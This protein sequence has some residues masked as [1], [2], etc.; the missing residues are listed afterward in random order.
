MKKSIFFILVSIVL[1]SCSKEDNIT[2][3]L[4]KVPELETS[5]KL[6][7]RPA[8]TNNIK[9]ITGK[10]SA[11]EPLKLVKKVYFYSDVIGL[12]QEEAIKDSI[13]IFK[14]TLKLWRGSRTDYEYDEQNQLKSTKKYIAGNNGNQVSTEINF[15]DTFSYSN[16]KVSTTAENRYLYDVKGNIIELKGNDG[17]SIQYSYDDFDRI[18]KAQRFMPYDNSNFPDVSA[19]RYIVDFLYLDN[20]SNKVNIVAEY[21]MQTYDKSGY[22]IKGQEHYTLNSDIYNIDTSKAGVYA[23]EA[24]YKISSFPILHYMNARNDYF[25]YLWT[26]TNHIT[27][28]LWYANRPI[29]EY[30]IY[31]KEGYLIKKITTTKY[32]NGIA[33]SITLFEY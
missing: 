26:P 12:T 6:K 30:Y 2:D 28:W 1:F 15:M 22:L 25:S 9:L 33:S 29:L 7:F 17:T 32:I 3:E 20:G 14:D 23:N 8:I 4:T 11:N 27:D 21:W 31:D 18:I 10:R 19:L 16:G 24:W 13:N 5:N